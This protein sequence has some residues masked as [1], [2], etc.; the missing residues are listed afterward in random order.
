MRIAFLY[1]EKKIGPSL[2]NEES[3]KYADFDPPEVMEAVKAALEDYGHEVKVIDADESAYIKLKELKDSSWIDFAFNISEG[4]RGNSRESHIPAKLEMLGIPYLGSDVLTSAIVL[5]KARTKEILAY[6]NIPTAPFELIRRKGQKLTKK[7]NF[8]LIVKPNA[9]GSS[10]G[11]MDDCLIE[12]ENQLYERIDQLI[13]KFNQPVIVEEFLEGKEFTVPVLGNSPEPIV[14][15]IVEI[16]FKD[17]PD[18]LKKFDSYEVKWIY[19]SPENEVDS[20]KC[21]AEIDPKLREQIIKVVKDA[22]SALNIYDWCRMDIRLDKNRIP[23]I[24][25]VNT[26]VGIMPDPKENSRFPLSARIAGLSY[27][28]MI[29]ALLM[30]ALERHNTELEDER[31][32]KLK[33]KINQIRNDMGD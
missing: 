12:N 24:I 6:N 29:N 32:N 23:N 21:P 30:F 7:L 22:Y 20:F 14:L 25:E 16:D 5:D 8:P 17:V 9:E 31:Y 10:K 13:D 18:N 1:N 2:K 4:I 19:D 28:E 26:P 11:I 27:E 3:L 33:E 15:P